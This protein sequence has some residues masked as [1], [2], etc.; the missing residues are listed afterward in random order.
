MHAYNV[1]SQTVP[2]RKF[3]ARTLILNEECYGRHRGTHQQVS[4]G[5]MSSSFT[6]FT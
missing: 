3:L 2:N 6:D 1:F 4:I 5:W